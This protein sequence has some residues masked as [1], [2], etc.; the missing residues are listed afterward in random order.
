[1]PILGGGRVTGK[2][3]DFDVGLVNIQTD[4]DP[5]AGAPSTNFSVVRLRRDV[6]ARSS[7]GMLFEN[8]SKALAGGGGNEAWGIDGSFGLSDE[9]S[10]LAYYANTDTPGLE[11]LDASYRGQVSYAGD[12]W[13]AR[14][15]HLVVGD[16][17]NPEVGFVRRDDF[18]QTTLM[19]RFSPRP[20]SIS[21]MRQLTLQADVDYLESESLGHVESR[22]WRGQ[23]GIDFESSDQLNVSFTESYENLIADESISGAVIPA[24]RYTFPELQVSYNLGPQ[25][26]VTGNLS[27][28][29]G[30]YYGGTLTS[31]GFNRGRVEL[32]PQV[33]IEPSLSLN[34]IDLPQGRFDQHVAVTRLTYTLT[35]RAY[36]SGLLQYNSGSDTFSGNFRLRW[37][38]APG[39][40]LFVVYTEDRTTD[41]TDRWSELRNRGFVIKV[42]RLFRL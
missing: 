13:G 26:P 2:V 12:E 37:E 41:I 40:E 35:P 3:G 42:N 9:L 22:S 5:A 30:D 34:W 32:T 10:L 38:W 33:S 6:F 29:T 17:F 20:R 1:V 39:S 8:R 24:G 21:W 11:G 19:G 27:V 7:I 25:R 4:D 36:V 16:D 18:R 31:I 14:V 15:D 23:A 28:R